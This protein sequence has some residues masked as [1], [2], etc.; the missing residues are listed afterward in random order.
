MNVYLCHTMSAF[1]TILNIRAS[2]T[3]RLL[4]FY[5]NYNKLK[6][7]IVCNLLIFIENF[8]NTG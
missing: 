7:E 4:P 6:Q 2:N 8:G 1:S 5:L 3:L